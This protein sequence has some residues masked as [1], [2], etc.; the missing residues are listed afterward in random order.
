MATG[1]AD[2]KKGEPEAGTMLHGA[3][4]APLR[5]GAATSWQL[6]NDEYALPFAISVLLM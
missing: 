5:W 6:A 1:K 4:Y 3:A 2:Q